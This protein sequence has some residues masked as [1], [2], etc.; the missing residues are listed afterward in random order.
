MIFLIYINLKQELVKKY[1]DLEDQLEKV[2]VNNV[3]DIKEFGEK[4]LDRLGVLEKEVTK[5]REEKVKLFI[6]PFISIP[7]FIKS[8]Y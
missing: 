4:F 7:I 6:L 2:K 8:F 1:S 3:K 5:L